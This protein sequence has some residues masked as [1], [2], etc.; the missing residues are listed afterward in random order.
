MA[1][2]DPLNEAGGGAGMVSGDEVFEKM[3]ADCL[4]FADDDK[5]LQV[6]LTSLEHR[7]YLAWEKRCAWR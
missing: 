2:A 5:L 4:S 6:R 7:L 3:V 1:P